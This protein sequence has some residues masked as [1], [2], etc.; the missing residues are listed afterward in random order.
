M[1]YF[2]PDSWKK[3]RFFFWSHKCDAWI[4]LP[5]YIVRHLPDT[6]FSYDGQPENLTIKRMDLSDEKFDEMGEVDATKLKR[7]PR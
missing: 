2:P 1:S 6:F 7:E 5:D 4:V 3:E